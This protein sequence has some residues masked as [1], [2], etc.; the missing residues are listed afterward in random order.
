MVLAC[1]DGGEGNDPE[2]FELAL[3]HQGPTLHNV[4]LLQIYLIESLICVIPKYTKIEFTTN[5][6]AQLAHNTRG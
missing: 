6:D 5:N 4:K 1:P 3:R 2:A